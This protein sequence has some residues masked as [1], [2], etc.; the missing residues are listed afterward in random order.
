MVFNPETALSRMKILRSVAL[1]NETMGLNFACGSAGQF[2]QQ[3]AACRS[4]GRLGTSERPVSAP[5]DGEHEVDLVF[6]LDR[7]EQS[8]IADSRT[9]G[10]RDPRFEAAFRDDAVAESRMFAIDLIHQFSHGPAFGV[11]EAPVGGESSKGGGD[12]HLR[13]RQT[14]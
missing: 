12:M 2:H 6:R 5:A 10:G 11:D 8:Q 7:F 14:F 4:P 9:P 3:A 1:R 13:H